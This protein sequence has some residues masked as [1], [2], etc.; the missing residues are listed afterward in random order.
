MCL[1][2][3][4]GS[5]SKEMNPCFFSFLALESLREM[6]LTKYNKYMNRCSLPCTILGYMYVDFVRVGQI[7]NIILIQV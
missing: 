2:M 6:Q 5:M 3:G 7:T 1:P 4:T